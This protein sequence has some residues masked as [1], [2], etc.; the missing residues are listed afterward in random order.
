MSYPSPYYSPNEQQN[1]PP[2]QPL[3]QEIHNV[4]SYYPPQV[5]PSVNLGSYSNNTLN[6]D[7]DNILSNQD[8]FKRDPFL[9]KSYITADDDDP[10]LEYLGIGRI[11]LINLKGDLKVLLFQSLQ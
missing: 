2:F 10:N 9:Y 5:Y 8:F 6:E 3:P 11:Q 4:S 1:Y 7:N